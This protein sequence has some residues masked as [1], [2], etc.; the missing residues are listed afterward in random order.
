M[1]TTL[2][3]GNPI[4][5]QLI[6]PSDYSTLSH[7][8]ESLSDDSKRRFGPHGFDTLSITEF[9]AQ[10]TIYGF[11][12]KELTSNNIIAYTVVKR[13][14]W[15]HD[16]FRYIGYGLTMSQQT[17]AT[18]APAVADLFQGSG[19]GFE[20]LKFTLAYLKN[21]KFER[22]FLWGGVQ[23]DNYKAIRFYERNGFVKLG[24]FEYHGYNYDMVL[25]LMR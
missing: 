22:V 6:T 11:V 14:F 20:L 5:L 13:G 18:L 7:F 21:E 9:Y 17:D 12:A 25:D 10:H 4:T 16:E 8:L 1:A 19:V 2:I 24:G 3:N 23:A 15:P